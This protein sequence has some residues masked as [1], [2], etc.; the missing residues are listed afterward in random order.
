LPWVESSAMNRNPSNGVDPIRWSSWSSRSPTYPNGSLPRAY[1]IKEPYPC[2]VCQ[3]WNTILGGNGCLRKEGKAADAEQTPVGILPHMW[4]SKSHR[5]CSTSFG[6][7][8]VLDVNKMWGI[9]RIGKIYGFVHE[10]VGA[11]AR[12]AQ[13]SSKIGCDGFSWHHHAT[14]DGEDMRLA[15][16]IR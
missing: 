12:W 16:P 9:S 4:S 5:S 14:A 10:R 3:V 11:S 8:I 6:R 13:R 15:K 7:S 2:G 1:K